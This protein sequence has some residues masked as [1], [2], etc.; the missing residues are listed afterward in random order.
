M[1]VLVCNLYVIERNVTNPLPNVEVTFI[2]FSAIEL[3][4]GTLLWKY[5][6]KQTAWR[7]VL[8]KLR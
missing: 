5:N 3:L 2:H 1:A 4:R 7:R 6:D 8:E